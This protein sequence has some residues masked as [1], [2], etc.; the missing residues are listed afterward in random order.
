MTENQKKVVLIHE[1]PGIFEEM[2]QAFGNYGYQILAFKKGDDI[3]ALVKDLES[4]VASIIET[5]AA[6]AGNLQAAE[7][8]KAFQNAFQAVKIKYARA[9]P[10]KTDE[11]RRLIDAAKADHSE[12]S[13]EAVRQLAHKLVGTAGSYGYEKFSTCM[14]KVE[15]LSVEIKKSP[16]GNDSAK[17]W[18]ELKIEFELAFQSAQTI[19]EEAIETTPEADLPPLGPVFARILLVDEDTTFL[20]AAENLGRQCNVS[21]LKAKNSA[22]AMNLALMHQLDAAIIDV[23]TE[24]QDSSFNLA[25]DLRNLPD[26]DTVPLAFISADAKMRP[27][28]EAAHVG[29]SLHLDKPLDMNSLEAAVRHLVAIRQGGR[30]KVMI[31]D[32][33][34]DFTAKVAFDLH[35]DNLLVRAVN[36][37]TKVLDALQEFP[38]DVLLLD[39]MM[40]G[41]NGFEVCKML[42]ELPRWRDLPIIFIT[43]EMHIDARV[44]AFVSGGDDY[45]PKPIVREELLARVRVRLEKSRLLKERSDKDGITG[46]LLRRAFV[47]QFNSML[48]DAER[49][50]FIL[51]ICIID[52]DFFKKVNDTYGHMA[53]DRVLA[54]FGQLMLRRFRVDDLRGRWGGEEF[55]LAFR[56]ET[57]ET[58]RAALERVQEELGSIAFESD[59][60]QKFN[61]SFSGGI[62]SFPEDGASLHELLAIADKRLYEAKHAGRRRIFSSNLG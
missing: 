30:P 19:A 37:S 9:L 38:P 21:V 33:D 51:S 58:M 7:K 18:N 31:V 13:I 44:K 59:D 4:P 52:I 40:P 1:D 17:L 14:R 5:S 8:L 29:A 20:D 26:Y 53:G 22:E 36:D 42:R 15:Q 55:I 3:E 23:R 24:S 12:Q 25:M 45:L 2:K 61:V 28:V 62:A 41:M 11:L 46:L 57:K 39:V 35:N 34:P 56:R 49:N 6:T 27:V 10:E 50:N 47:E 48:F 60:G 16:D 32:D 54:R 43:A